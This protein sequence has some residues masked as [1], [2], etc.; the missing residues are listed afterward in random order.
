[1]AISVS[2]LRPLP[3]YPYYLKTS[4]QASHPYTIPIAFRPNVSPSTSA[5][6]SFIIHVSSIHEL[7]A[8]K[9]RE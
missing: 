1:M 5:L 8:K 9:S 7:T 4:L 2:L 3:C 6:H